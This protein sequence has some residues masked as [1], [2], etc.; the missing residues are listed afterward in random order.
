MLNRSRAT[1]LLEQPMNP[2]QQ[3]PH[4]MQPAP[5]HMTQRSG[6]SI[7]RSRLAAGL[8]GEEDPL[9]MIEEIDEQEVSLFVSWPRGDIAQRLI[10]S[11][12]HACVCV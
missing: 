6:K 2:P 4:R 10:E 7:A 8:R 1:T 3:P 5:S 11:S 12:L 9:S